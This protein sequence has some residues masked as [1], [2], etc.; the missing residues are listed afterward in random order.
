MMIKMNTKANKRN[1][2]IEE[3]KK[4]RNELM[5]KNSKQCNGKK[6]N[7]KHDAS[8]FDRPLF[9]HFSIVFWFGASRAVVCLV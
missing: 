5:K 1:P 7:E 9:V 8:W 4:K 6:M 2:K 3:E